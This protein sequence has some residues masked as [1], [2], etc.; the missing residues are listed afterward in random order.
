MKVFRGEAEAPRLVECAISYERRVMPSATRRE[1]A[2]FYEGKREQGG[3]ARFDR[4]IASLQVEILP[5][6]PDQARLAREAFKQFG[7]SRAA[8]AAHA[9]LPVPEAAGRRIAMPG[10]A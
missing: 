6:T 4:I 9:R 3:G 8:K 5:F 10:K 7:K 1:C 2:I